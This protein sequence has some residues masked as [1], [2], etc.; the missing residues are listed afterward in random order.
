MGSNRRILVPMIVLTVVIGIIVLIAAVYLFFGEMNDP[1]EQKAEVALNVLMQEIEN[2]KNS[3]FIAAVAS[4]RNADLIDA[5]LKKDKEKIIDVQMSLLENSPLDY[6]TV[7]Y[8][9]GTVIHRSHEPERSGDS[10]AELPQIKSAMA[11]KSEAFIMQGITIPLGIAAGS[12]IYDDDM[13]LIGLI[14]IGYRLDSQDLVYKLKDI[15]EA[16]ISIFKGDERIASTIISED[17]THP[18]GGKADEEISKR[19]LAGETYSGRVMIFG[20]DMV[21]IYAPLLGANDEV[22][23]M[24]FVGFFTAGSI[25]MLS[26]FVVNGILITISILAVCLIVAWNQSKA[27]ERRVDNIM[28]EVDAAHTTTQAMFESNPHINVLFD[29]D[30]KVIDCNP[31][32]MEFFGYKDKAEFIDGFVSRLTESLPDKQADGSK[33]I[34]ITEGFMKAVKDGYVKIDAD[35]NLKGEEKSLSVELKKIPYKDDF[36]IVAYVQ[37]MTDVH[38]RELELKRIN[39]KN[40]FQVTLLN[41][42]VKATK[43]ALWDA[44]IE[45]ENPLNPETLVLW[46][47]EFISM[48]GYDRDSFSDLFQ[49][50]IDLLHPDDKERAL[51]EFAAHLLDTTGTVPFNSEYRLLKKNGEYAYFYAAGDTIRD[52]EGNPIHAM[53]AIMDITETKNLQR[54]I[55]SERSTL[56]TIF[57]AIP[58][59]I[60]CKDDDLRFTR[61]NQSLLQFFNVEQKDLIG[62]HFINEQE[63]PDIIANR[64]RRLDSA[65]LKENK[66]FTDEEYLS[67]YL[68]NNRLFETT[69]LP[70]TDHYGNVSGLMIVAR[71]ITER[72]AVE[73]ATQSANRSKTLFLANMSHEI[74]T[75]MNSIIGFT[76]LAQ[77]DDIPTRTRA[78]LNNIQESAEWLLRIINDILDISKIEAGRIELE[79]VPFDLPSIFAQCQSAIIPRTTEKGIMLYCYA[80]PSIGKKLLGDPVRLRQVLMN[81]LSNAVKFTNTGTVKFLASL[82]NS[83]ENSVTVQ[84]EVKDS[85]IGMTPEQ[86]ERVFSPFMQA[87]DSITRRFGGTG[88]GLTITKNIIEL[89]GGKL[90]VQSTPDVGSKFSFDI[91]FDLVDETSI[92]DESITFSDL[93]KPN[94]TGEILVCEDNKLNQQVICDHL[95]RVGLRTVVANNGKEGVDIVTKR[96]IGIANEELNDK[97]ISSNPDKPFDLIFMDIHMPVMDGLEAALKITGM[98]VKTP[99]VAITANVMSNDMELYRISG[100]FDTLGKPFTA[101]DL[102][103]CLAKYLPID[104]Y[105]AIDKNRQTADEVKAQNNLRMNFVRFNKNT[106]DELIRSVSAGDISKAH[107]IAHTLK[108]NAAQLDEKSLHGAAAAVEHSLAD[109]KNRLTDEKKDALRNELAAVFSRY[110]SLFSNS[111]FGNGDIVELEDSKTII[112]ILDKL[113]PLLENINPECENMLGDIRTIPDS[114]LLVDC[115]EGFNFERALDELRKI[116]NIWRNKE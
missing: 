31:A 92:S 107:R 76:E 42:V 12:P 106:Y 78:Y 73:E 23:G 102:W 39:A 18:L 63:L 104:G 59:L 95:Q 13:N 19:V 28:G 44:E 87:D 49:A 51:G 110:S 91:E 67:D 71:D 48:V 40:E 56:Q 37:D 15:S 94:F 17:G 54:T 114:E 5:L 74:R 66:A 33:S 93:Q 53:G 10:L 98:G 85:G 82:T 9:N 57:D 55:E 88:L 84:F 3:A 68:G 103:I 11:G 24:V 8:P 62:K 115:I 27:I 101:Q 41:T 77:D 72:K 111:V 97:N 89:M 80:E 26:L 65:V 69:R 79:R 75:P 113:E 100:M 50:W 60:F 34:P 47:D 86:I 45:K 43:I 105:T 64:Y 52:D 1:A 14:S 2:F 22:I 116:K 7:L 4:A 70:L 29:K 36:A 32:A 46:S 58:D 112:A 61:C 6:I 21:C 35:I 30:F 38:N 25:N 81:L 90:N 83:S 109:G 96:M 20:R 108:S 16:E 99:I